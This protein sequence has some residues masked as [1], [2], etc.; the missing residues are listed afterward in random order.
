MEKKQKKQKKNKKKRKNKRHTYGYQ[1]GK[2]K[3]G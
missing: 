3:E 2:R 1:K